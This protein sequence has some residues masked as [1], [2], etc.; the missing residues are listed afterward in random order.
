MGSSI[1]RRVDLCT[2]RTM[3]RVKGAVIRNSPCP[4]G[5]GKKFKKCCM[6]NDVGE[7][8]SLQKSI[9]LSDMGLPNQTQ[10]IVAVP[11]YAGRGDPRNGKEPGG[12]PGPYKVIF[13]LSKPRNP[14]VDEMIVGFPE[15]LEGNSHLAITK[16]AYV[17]PD[18]SAATNIIVRARN[19]KGEEFKFIGIPNQNGF[20]GKIQSDSFPAE[21]LEDALQKAHRILMPSLSNWSTCLDIPL[22]IESI[23]VTEITSGQQMTT[24]TT[25]YYESPFAI[26]PRSN[27]T[28]EFRLYL[29]LYREALVSNSPVYQ[30][31]CFYKIIESIRERRSRLKAEAKMRGEQYTQPKE[32]MPTNISDGIHWLNAIYYVR[33]LRWDNMALNLIFKNLFNVK[34][35]KII[36]DRLRPLRKRIAHAIT[37]DGELGVCIDDISTVNEVHGW[38]PLTKCLVRH[39]LKDTFPQEYLSNLD[40]SGNQNNKQ[41]T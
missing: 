29:S 32:R 5:S 23:Q 9:P 13:L 10:Y 30:F 40:S 7:T 33:P 31:L 17:L 8:R 25:P 22:H 37:D 41:S 26:M 6:D 34:Y 38:L 3:E 39:M 21:S 20:L 4:C 15:H 2:D 24:W 14:V 35:A 11:E 36:D 19:D 1:S 18:G 28:P 16:P 27:L 12:T